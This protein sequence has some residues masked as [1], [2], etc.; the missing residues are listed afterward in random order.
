M[1]TLS[2]DPTDPE[3]ASALLPC[4]LSVPNNPLDSEWA[5]DGMGQAGCRLLGVKSLTGGPAVAPSP[6]EDDT[7]VPNPKNGECHEGQQILVVD[8]NRDAADSLA[9]LFGVMGAK[10]YVAYGGQEALIVMMSVQPRIA[11]I[12]I[13][14]PVMDGYELATQIRARDTFAGVVLIALTGWGQTRETQGRQC[15]FDHHFTK[16]ADVRQ[17][18]RLLASLP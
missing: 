8:D 5:I 6:P 2:T 13:D 11:F 1:N 14:M 7:R 12:D 16:P 4:I 10:A 3:C 18:T 9:Q 15:G 17:L